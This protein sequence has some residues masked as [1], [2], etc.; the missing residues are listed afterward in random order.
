MAAQVEAQ[1]AEAVAECGDLSGLGLQR[2]GL[3]GDEGQDRR[4]FGTVQGVMSREAVDVDHRHI[5][6]PNFLLCGPAAIHR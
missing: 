6:V 5:G 2:E 3:S 4:I 1:D